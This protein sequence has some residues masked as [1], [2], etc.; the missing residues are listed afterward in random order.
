MKPSSRKIAIIG[1]S[2]FIGTRLANRLIRS[3]YNVSIL[4]KRESLTHPELWVKSDVRDK[5]SM[6]ELEESFVIY[7][8]AA[9]HRD[10]VTPR[11]LYWDVNVHGAK[12]VCAVAEEVGINRIIFTSSVAVYGF[13]QFE[14]DESGH[15]TPFNEYGKTKLEA[16]TVY[17]AWQEKSP[18]RSLIIVRP[19]VVFGEA[20]RGNVYNLLN[21]IANGKFIMIGRGTNQKS[22]AYVENVAA[23][24]EFALS[25]IS[26]CHVFNYADKPDFDMNSL[27]ST[28]REKLGKSPGMGAR[29]PYWLGYFGGLFFDALSGITSRKFPISSI[30][31]K[32]FCANTQFTSLQLGEVGFSP[33]VPLME[34]LK[35]TIECEF[36]DRH[37]NNRILFYSE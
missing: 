32:K 37:V 33:P 18:D 8:L 30:R 19:T 31:I 14:T 5:G 16:E 10:D 3:G 23:F 25:L 12:N 9:E 28:V 7:N 35:R 4:D 6:K 2:G 34:G 13:T 20:N 27:V 36:L 17:K 29:I 21:Q 24:L 22:M 15:L 11:S 26:G 1:G